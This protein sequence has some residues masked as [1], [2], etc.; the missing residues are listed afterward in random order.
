MRNHTL[1]QTIARAN[2]VFGDKV[3]GLIVD[4]VGV[5]RDL[6]KALAIYAGG[7]AG[8]GGRTPV[9]EKKELIEMLKKAIAEATE[10]CQER[11]VSVDALLQTKALERVKALKDARDAIL[12]NDDTKKKF[13]ALAGRTTLVYRAILPDTSASQFA[14]PCALFITLADMIRS[15]LPPGGHLRGHAADRGRAGQ[16]HRRQRLHHQGGSQAAGPEPRSISTR[17]GSSSRRH[18]SGRRLSGSGPRSRPSSRRWS[19]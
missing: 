12:V 15:L 3:N 2:R 4:Y 11:G 5:F 6:Q 8:G 16:V 18:I 1:M 13:L 7:G 17:C 10:F 19:R 9:E 14:G